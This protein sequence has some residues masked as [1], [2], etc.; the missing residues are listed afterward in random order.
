[1]TAPPQ[2]PPPRAPVPSLIKWLGS[3]IFHGVAAGLLAGSLLAVTNNGRAQLLAMQDDMLLASVLYL[4]I[5][6]QL[7]ASTALVIGS[8]LESRS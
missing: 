8:C 6:A 4:Q 1:M 3:T 7:G 2:A 5:C